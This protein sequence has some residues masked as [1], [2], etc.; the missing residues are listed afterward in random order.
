MIHAF[1]DEPAFR[2]LSAGA[3]MLYVHLKR[4]HN[5][6]NNG[7]LFLSVRRAASLLNVSKNTSNKFFSEL[8]EK[9]FIV[10]VEVGRLGIEGK[11]KATRWRL[12]E[13]GYLGSRG[14]Q[15]YKNWKAEI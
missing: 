7:Q 14:T 12:T 5:G 6:E 4:H 3:Q 15:D 8:Q 1:M 11:G 2:S 9:G 10:A 13:I